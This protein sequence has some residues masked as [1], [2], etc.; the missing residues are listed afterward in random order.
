MIDFEMRKRFYGLQLFAEDGGGTGD[1]GDDGGQGANSN[2]GGGNGEPKSSSEPLSFEDFLKQGDNQAELDRRINKAVSSAV[3][4]A[5]EKWELETDDKLSEAEKLARMNK[6]QKAEYKAKKLEEE[7]AQMKR[8]KTIAEMAKTA[9]KT[10]S[11]KKINVPDEILS[12]L[13]TEDAEATGSAI[14]AFAELFNGAVSEEL[15]KSAR[16][17]TPKEG[18]G[19]SGGFEKQDIAKLAKEARII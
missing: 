6:E 19:T 7:L 14:E 9:R 17:D 4:N 3:K 2:E 5:R 8:E 18:G 15:K 16:Q 13:V 11:E 1:T 12:L 10:L